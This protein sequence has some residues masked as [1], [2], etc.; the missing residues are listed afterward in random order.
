MN[1]ALAVCFALLAVFGH[2]QSG[3]ESRPIRI[4]GTLVDVSEAPVP[5]P[6]SLKLL[7]SSEVA[8]TAR[9]NGQGVFAISEVKRGKYVLRIEIPGFR[10]YAQPF[11]V[12][13]KTDIDLGRV[14]LFG[15]Q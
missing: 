11:D 15:P 13:G 4:S 5:A 14:Q 6:V 10:T 2:G 9:T 1:R 12:S 8:S 7:D 3:I